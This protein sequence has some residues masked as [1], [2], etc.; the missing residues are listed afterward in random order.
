MCLGNLWYS[1]KRR[2][3]GAQPNDFDWATDAYPADSHSVP[4]ER[5]Y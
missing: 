5:K 2:R 4:S 3:F 1:V